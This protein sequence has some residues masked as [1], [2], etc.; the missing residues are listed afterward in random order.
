MRSNGLKTTSTSAPTSSPG[1]FSSR[2]AEK[3]QYLQNRCQ[4]PPEYEQGKTKKEISTNLTPKIH[5][6]RTKVA[7]A[8]LNV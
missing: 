2:L 3:P 1:L 5:H 6:L 8:G 4:I 7:Y